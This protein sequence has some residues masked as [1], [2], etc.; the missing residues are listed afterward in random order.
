M[1]LVSIGYS[2]SNPKFSYKHTYYVAVFTELLQ[3]SPTPREDLAEL[4][5]NPDLA[6]YGGTTPFDPGVSLDSPELQTFFNQMSFSKIGIFYLHHLGRLH[7]DLDRLAPY[8]L[9]VRP[10]YYGNYEKSAGFPPS[11][12]SRTFSFW[13]DWKKKYGPKTIVSFE[14]PWRHRSPWDCDPLLQETYEGGASS[15]GTTSTDIGHGGD[16][17]SH[18]NRNHGHHRPSETDIPIQRVV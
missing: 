3:H 14:A 12:M 8:A 4:G 15:I 7:K 16:A 18:R 2:V 17:A 1:I 6:K 11:T 9:L 5:V 13:S 10:D